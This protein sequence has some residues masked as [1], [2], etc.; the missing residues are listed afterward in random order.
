MRAAFALAA[1]LAGAPL[2]AETAQAPVAVSRRVA[3]MGTTAEIEIVAGSRAD[4]L[5][6]SE[7]AVKELRRVEDLLTT[8]RDS[9]LRRL[10]EA[11]PGSDVAV[12]AELAAALRDVFQWSARTGRA[13]DPTVAP[14]MRA[15]DLRGAGRIASPDEIAAALAAVGTAHFSVDAGHGTARRL[16]HAAGLDEGAWGKGY[17]LDTSARA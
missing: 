9:P 2:A 7:I 11:P 8:W 4:G 14:L 13:F 5:A 12:G 1:A 16:H 3:S 10:N 6:A 15:W 17:A